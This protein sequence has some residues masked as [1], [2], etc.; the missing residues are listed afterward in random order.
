ML[1]QV[2]DLNVGFR[3]H[4]DKIPVLFDVSLSVD[5]GELVALVGES[6]SGK[7]VTALTIAGL[8]PPQA[9]VF[10]GEVLLQG[11]PLSDC[12][13]QQW[14]QLR[15]QKIS[16]IFQ[17]PISSLNPV[18][19]IGEQLLDALQIRRGLS[20]RE[21]KAEAVS[22]LSQVKLSDPERLLHCYPHQLSGGMC[23]RVVIA[24]ALCSP[25]SGLLIA[26]EPTTALDVTIQAQILLLLQQLQH[27]RGDGLL[28]I[29][30]DMGVV[31]QIATRVIVMYKGR[32]VEEADTATIFTEARHPYTVGLID[33]LPQDQLQQ[34]RLQSIPGQLPEQNL[35]GCPFA[36]RC[37]RALPVCRR[38]F[39]ALQQGKS[40]HHFFACHNPCGTKA[41]LLAPAD[42]EKLLTGSTQR[43]LAVRD[44]KCYFSLRSKGKALQLRALDGVSLTLNR[45]ELLG[46]VGESG[47]GKS[48]LA[49]CLLNLQ[50]LTA[51][52]IWLDQQRI[53]NLSPAAMR[54]YRRRLQIILQDPMTALNP[55]KKIGQLLQEPLTIHEKH[56][57]SA[58]MKNR[59][60]KSIAEVGL[61]SDHLS[62]FPHQLSG[63]QRQRLCIA[64]ALILQPDLIVCDESVS[65]LDLSI[66]AQIVNL[67]LD[68]KDSHNLSYLFIS[69]DLGVVEFVADR[70]L[71]LYLGRVVEE[72]DNINLQ[73]NALHPYTRALLASFPSVKTTRKPLEIKGEPL[74]PTALFAGC[75]FANR[76]PQVSAKCRQQSPPLKQVEGGH[77]VAC[78]LY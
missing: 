41:T 8:L 76:C 71:V 50:P 54:A 47:C 63:G 19:T 64:R 43:L 55:R 3:S 33:S 72:L 77:K 60:A 40:P 49:R 74:S 35:D 22:L 4:G 2:Q 34:R 68:F 44:V 53:D 6:G 39:P 59:I 61:S 27:Q 78:W 11:R 23:Q 62:R 48:T 70:I 13:E 10:A 52:E 38:E 1:L 17:E 24:M 42:E 26:D 65:A 20:R 5:H 28:L 31:Y 12:N 69:H 25:Q 51:G 15:R 16:M 58:E 21:A 66:Q 18:L 36:P 45:G 29:T 7:S 67:L 9:K 75:H 30:H 57:S 73:Q 56:L 37:Q 32:K 14:Q 46:V